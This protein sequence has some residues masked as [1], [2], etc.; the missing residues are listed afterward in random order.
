MKLLNLIHCLLELFLIV[1]LLPVAERYT[2]HN[3]SNH[4]IRLP[5]SQA[6]TGGLPD[7]QLVTAV[8]D[9]Y[10]SRSKNHAGDYKIS[11]GSTYSC[12]KAERVMKRRG[13]YS[14]SLV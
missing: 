2:V 3:T 6:R 12:T 9:Q 4:R 11:V 13:R 10:F 1:G 7:S 8:I 5:M 14:D